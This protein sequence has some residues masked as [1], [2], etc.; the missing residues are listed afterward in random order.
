MDLILCR[1]VSIYF[2]TETVTHLVDKF[3][4]TLNPNGYLL[5]GHAE[6]Q[7][8]VHPLLH[9]KSYPESVVYLRNVTKSPPV[10]S[11]RQ[12]LQP[13]IADVPTGASKG[14]LPPP[15]VAVP[16]S[17]APEKPVT[18]LH[19]LETLFCQGR[20]QEVIAK[21]KQITTRHPHHFEAWQLMT[22]AYAN[23]G[24]Y[25]EAEVC[26]EYLLK[27]NAFS[28]YAYYLKAHIAMDRGDESETKALLKKTLYLDPNFIAPHLELA[29]IYAREG[30]AK[31]AR[32]M[33]VTACDLL[34]ALPSGTS[35]K[36][37]DSG[38]A[39]TLLQEVER[40]L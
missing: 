27:I 16:K 37:I 8:I 36:M 28:A 7:G 24:Q 11:T 34:R 30:D 40:L 26:C 39:D 31:K 38:T 22:R 9:T 4:N 20:Y 29:E 2:S 18:E 12:I 19:S 17:L 10:V 23:L 21:T 35:V 5:T 13:F 1:N 14:L 6:L 25:Q 33:R 15:S 3:V 32:K